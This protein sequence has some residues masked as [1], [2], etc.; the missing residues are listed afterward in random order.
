VL[1]TIVYKK[2][3]LPLFSLTTAYTVMASSW[4]LT[5]AYDWQVKV[6]LIWT[7]HYD[8]KWIIFPFRFSAI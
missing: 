8:F 6:F 1:L 4:L 5:T 7:Y 2:R 3:K